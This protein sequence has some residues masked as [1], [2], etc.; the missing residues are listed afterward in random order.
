MPVVQDRGEA[1]AAESGEGRIASGTAGAAGAQTPASR[2]RNSS[3]RCQ[4]THSCRQ[5]WQE[6]RWR[7]RPKFVSGSRNSCIM[8]GSGF[9]AP[10]NTIDRLA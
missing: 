1:G 9:S 7:M 2:A 8:I 3:P 10:E 5:G 6:L 4:L